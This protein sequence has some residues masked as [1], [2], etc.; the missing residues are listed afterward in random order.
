M[1]VALIGFLARQ[2]TTCHCPQGKGGVG[3]FDA[4]NFRHELAPTYQE[5][6]NSFARTP[7]A[8]GYR[9]SISFHD[10]FGRA[11]DRKLRRAKIGCRK[12]Q[13]PCRWRSSRRSSKFGLWFGD[14]SLGVR[15]RTHREKRRL[16]YFADP[17]ALDRH[18]IGTR[19]QHAA[20]VDT[21][22]QILDFKK[23]HEMNLS[24]LRT[25]LV[26]KQEAVIGKLIEW[27]LQYRIDQYKRK[28]WELPSIVP[29]QGPL[30]TQTQNSPQREL[31]G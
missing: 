28:I 11:I 9:W 3:C 18:S 12:D 29:L 16:L 24:E 2:K 17:R 23:L 15:S 30:P 7:G 21:L 14:L 26:E 27:R 20:M 5:L 8:R 13:G 4:G 31:A 22:P 19:D 1:L 6:L 10:R 25:A